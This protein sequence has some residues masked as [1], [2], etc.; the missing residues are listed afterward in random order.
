MFSCGFGGR[1]RAGDP[2]LVCL[3]NWMIVCDVCVSVSLFVG[4]N[5]SNKPRRVGSLERLCVKMNFL[6]LGTLS[7]NILHTFFE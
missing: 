3:V 4:L 7:L 6:Y 5:I 1:E 2:V